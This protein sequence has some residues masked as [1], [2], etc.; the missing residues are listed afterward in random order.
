MILPGN[1]ENTLPQIVYE[2]MDGTISIKGR[3]IS[4][5]VEDYFSDFLPYLKDCIEKKPMDMK[6]SFDF[7][8]FNT[9]TSKLL[10]QLLYTV[11]P[12]EEQG[13]K[14]DITW[15]YEE[16]DDDMKDIGEDYEDLAQIKFTFIEKP[17]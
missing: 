6:I 2:E 7:E 16:G 11:K 3:S 12:L 10:M 5:E 4:P 8:Y 1:E 9:K 15:T 13:F 14:I 17:E